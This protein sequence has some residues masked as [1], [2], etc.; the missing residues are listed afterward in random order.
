MNISLASKKALVTGGTHGIG[1]AI[2][3]RLNKSGCDVAV[4]SRDENKVKDTKRHLD[5]YSN[6]NLYYVG[7][8][9]CKADFDKITKDIDIKWGG[10]DILIN[11]VGGGGR[12]G[13]DFMHETDVSVWE[14]VFDK[15]II[16]AV[17]YTKHFLPFMI[18]N[19]WGRVICISSIYG[20]DVGGRPWF[21]AAK[22]SQNVIMK[23][24][25]QKH[26]YSSSNIT[27]NSV[28]PGPIYIE[29][30]GWSKLKNERPIEFENYV[31]DNIPRGIMGTA[32]E[33]ANVV[34][35]L[36][37][38]KSSLINGAVIPCDGGQGISI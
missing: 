5:K 21:N 30:T 26:L 12:W 13:N 18:K 10:V 6:N 9:T 20:K 15:N 7:D 25:S 33:V 22:S 36:C 19:N 23:N 8:A 16:A 1:K 2:A 34:C 11:N 17:R 35:F 24:L 29:N 28:A 4:F 27:F 3:E 14:E 38:D 32:S 31:A 37:S